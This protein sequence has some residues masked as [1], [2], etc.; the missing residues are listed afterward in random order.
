MSGSLDG[1]RGRVAL[2]VAGVLVLFLPQSPAAAEKVYLEDGRMYVGRFADL[3]GVAVN[4]LNPNQGGPGVWKA[5]EFCDDDLTRT[6]F[7]KRLIAKVDASAPQRWEHFEIPQP[8]ADQGNPIS[9][10]GTILG[11][12]PWDRFGRRT[13]TI[14]TSKG[15]ANV[16]QGLTE[17]TPAWTKVESLRGGQPY[18]WDM[19]IAT[20]SLPRDLISTILSR[21]IDRTNPDHRLRLVR[22]YMQAERFTDAEAELKGVVHDFPNLDG[23][24]FQIKAL[25]QLAAERAIGEIE[26]RRR[27]G[28]VRL[29]FGML[30]SFPTENISGPVLQEVRDKIEE[31]R[32]LQARGEKSIKL[33]DDLLAQV[34]DSAL[35]AQLEPLRKE[36]ADE[37]S[38]ATL[39]RLAAFR[40]LADDKSLLPEQRLALAV[41]GWLLGP[42]DTV[43]NVQVALSLT[44]TRNLVRQYLN[45]PLKINREQI[46]ESLGSQQASSPKYVSKLLAHRKPPAKTPPQETPGFFQL[47]VRGA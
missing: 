4:P 36:L 38:F 2:A 19:R 20:S 9:S 26:T 21:Q 29:A 30:Q 10:I 44:E 40:R 35:K 41:S 18:L 45:E 42:D 14:Q 43:D 22:F 37:L 39:D 15:A 25:A 12:T 32:T 24:D 6:M 16:I 23:M 1:S 8:V 13:Y 46:L 31:L 7:P 17:I 28:Q 3:A 11:Q 34:K 47:E 5:I 33:F 27:A